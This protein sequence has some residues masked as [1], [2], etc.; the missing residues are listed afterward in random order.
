MTGPRH[1]SVFRTLAGPN[2]RTV[3][4][5]QLFE[6][7]RILSAQDEIVVP[8]VPV[9]GDGELGTWKVGERVEKEAVEEGA[10]GR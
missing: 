7:E 6:L 3:S 10:N 5:V 2:R 4:L 9:C 1:R 8:F